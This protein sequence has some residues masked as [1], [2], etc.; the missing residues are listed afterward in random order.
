MQNK[1]RQWIKNVGI[2]AFLFFL[3]KGLIWLA[4]FFFAAKSCN[5]NL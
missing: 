3:I 4:V 2:G 5:I 1:N